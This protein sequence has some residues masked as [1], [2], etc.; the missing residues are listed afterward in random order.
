MSATIDNV[1][2]KTFDY[3]IC[4]GGTAGLTVAARLTEDPNTSVL[5]LEAGDAN[6]GDMALLLPAAYCSQFGNNQY[7]WPHQTTKQK[8]SDGHAYMWYRGRGLGGSSGINFHCWIKPPA[9]EIDDIERLGNPGWNWKNFEKYIKRTERFTPPSEE[10]QKTLNMNFDN[11]ELGTDGPLDI[12]YPASIDPAE[13]KVQEMNGDPVGTYYTPI[14]YDPKTHTRSYATTA[15]YLPNKDRPN[16]TVLP[17]AYVSRVL[18]SSQ[19]TSEFKAE[20]VEF[21]HNGQVYTVRANKEIILSAG[22][23]KTPQILELSGIGDPSV[24]RPLNIPVKVDLPGLGTNVQEHFTLPISFEIRDDVPFETPDG[25]SDPEVFKKHLELRPTGTGAFTTGIIGVTFATLA[26]IS[27]RAEEII[28]GAEEKIR[29]N[30]DKLSP[31][32]R[33]QYRISLDRL[34]NGAGCEFV[35]CAGMVSQPNPAEKGKRYLSFWVAMNH[36]FSRGT[37]HCVSNDPEVDP[38]FDPHYFEEEVDLQ[39]SVEMVKFARNLK[40]ISPLK[41]MIARE[42]N[43]GPEI[44]TDEQIATHLKQHMMT[45]HHTTG[46]CSMLPRE[47]GGVVD[48]QLRVYGTQNLRVVDLSVIP[49]IFAAHPQA[50]VYGVAEQA[51]DIIKGTFQP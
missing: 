23:L 27:P 4:G 22:S 34:R 45:T 19:S 43:P 36:T 1:Q 10:I 50:V 44:Q 38:E 29:K 3:I 12:A 39:V 5:L 42:H 25:V 26:Q 20:A 7:S 16:L 17:S 15:F 47:L 2:D 24:L 28:K 33:E 49:L 11:W 8:S 51:A 14:T 41:E 35:T 32:L 37:I 18:P 46:P 31:A 9:S 48:P 21:R 30:E 13:R 40:N 6:I